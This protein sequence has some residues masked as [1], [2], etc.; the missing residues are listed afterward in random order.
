MGKVI[1][2]GIKLS[3]LVSYHSKLPIKEE[4]HA[5]RP[6]RDPRVLV[7]SKD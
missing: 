7:E 5:S 2:T 1:G 6:N 4:R 3:L